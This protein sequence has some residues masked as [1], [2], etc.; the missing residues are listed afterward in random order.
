MQ[1]AWDSNL[2]AMFMFEHISKKKMSIFFFFFFFFFFWGGGG[3]G[4]QSN[5]HKNGMFKSV[6]KL[7]SPDLENSAGYKNV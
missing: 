2:L 4:V 7:N 5:F 3:G 1:K 6:A